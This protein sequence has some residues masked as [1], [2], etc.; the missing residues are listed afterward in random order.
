MNRTRTLII[1]FALASAA[2]SRTAN[3]T[4][5]NAPAPAEKAVDKEAAFRTEPAS[6]RVIHIAYDGG[7]CQA[8]IPI[9][10]FKGFFEA[11]GL[12]TELT[13]TGGTMDNAR[14]A[15]AGGKIDTSAGM[16]AGW[17]KPITNGVDIRFTVGLH[18]GCASAFVLANS[19]ITAFA[20]GQTIAIN[21]GIG[22]V[23]HNISYRFI[24]H[25]GFVPGD[26]TWRDFPADQTLL[27]LQNGDADV[28]VMADQVA[29]KWVQDGTLRRIRSLH[30]DADFAGE[31]CCVMGIAGPFLDE[32]PI[33]SEKIS[34]AV[35]KAALW[36][37][38][39]DA[40]K[41]EAAQLLLDNG[42]ISGTKEYALSLMKL[43]RWGLPNDLTEATLYTSVDEY[44]ALG[45]ISG[46]LSAED[47]KAQIWVPLDIES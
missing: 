40:N 32:N 15:L 36:I 4:T 20:K 9:A 1:A 42:Y 29:E 41:E 2:C 45:V 5:A 38:E 7:L 12:N 46:T 39:S 26:F 28:A 3:T 35:Y 23:Y 34:R 21:G 14:D 24:A 27:V 47:V 25:N 19:N 6:R 33:A 18:T 8:A 30:G 16:I 10:Q 22:G 44:Q 11:E 31:A 43:F 17:L 37:G 13:R